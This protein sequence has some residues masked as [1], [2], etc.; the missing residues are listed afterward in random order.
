ME[1][2]WDIVLNEISQ[3]Q[4][5]KHRVIPPTQVVQGSQRVKWCL[6]GGGGGRANGDMG[7]CCSVGVE[8][9]FYKVRKL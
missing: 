4:E 8:F 2:L 5:N 6:L 3:P 7:S 1:E 9:Q